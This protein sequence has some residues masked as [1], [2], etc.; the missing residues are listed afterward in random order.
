MN[1]RAFAAILAALLQPLVIGVASAQTDPLGQIESLAAAGRLTDARSLLQRWQGDHPTDAGDVTPAARA[2]SL[3]LQARLATDPE[4]AEEAYVAIALGYPTSA[5]APEAILRIGQGLVASGSVEGTS[6]P[7]ARKAVSYLQRLVT[8]YPGTPE[9]TEGLLWLSRAYQLSARGTQACATI[10]DAI[11]E[12]IADPAMAAR[13]RAEREAAC[14]A[15][16]AMPP[17]EHAAPAAATTGWATPAPPAARPAGRYA[18][19]SAA[20]RDATG[21][22][23]LVRRLDAAGFPAR[24]VVIGDGT[25][26]RVRVGAYERP[27]DA[28]A[29]ARRMRAAGFEAIVVDDVR[30]ERAA[31]R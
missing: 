26:I 9:R 29:A 20:V 17:L 6:G 11:R 1:A 2:R 30:D 18:V 23:D 4:A 3:L 22:R 31:G 14:G 8:D 19:Q 12:G 16:R 7:S 24:T 10:E 21:A 5:A 15:A 13:F 25:L 27:D 28:Q